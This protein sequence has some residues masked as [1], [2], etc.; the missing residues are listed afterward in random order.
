MATAGWKRLHF[1][2]KS[3]DGS[4]KYHTIPEDDKNDF[5]GADDS[6]TPFI[7]SG[8]IHRHQ[9]WRVPSCNRLALLG[10]LLSLFTV[11]GLY[12]NLRL[13]LRPPNR[14]SCG[15]SIEEAKGK[16]CV[17][18]T[19]SKAWLPPECPLYGLDEYLEAGVMAS[20]DTDRPWPF[21]SD[22][23]HKH[24]VS[25]EEMSHM[26]AAYKGGPEF[27]TSNREH[28]THCAWMLARMAHA[29]STGQRRDVNSD[30]F[31]HNKHCALYLLSRALD[32]PDI[33]EIG[34]RGN[35]IFGGC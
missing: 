5:E 16:G 7:A 13:S 4:E 14:L 9:K 24:E 35:V 21:Y 20:N 31:E 15:R 2:W 10:L 33:D 18:D 34:V 32:A 19:L 3:Q 8:P 29:Y 17:F 6:N 12:T 27:R 30:N 28:V 11:T 26:A 23:E 22:K 25:V 1:K